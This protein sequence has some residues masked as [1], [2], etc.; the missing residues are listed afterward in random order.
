V[1]TGNDYQLL[2]DIDG[3]PLGGR[4]PWVQQRPPPRLEMTSMAGPFG[5][6]W[7]FR[8]RPPPILKTM[9]MA[10][11]LG[12]LLVGP[13]ASTIEV[14]ED[15]DGRAPGGALPVGLAASVSEF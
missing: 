8:R 5:H 13:I 6:Y 7:W 15:V 14:E 11:P 4:C 1:D 2:Q 12:A 3:A 9:S 10:G